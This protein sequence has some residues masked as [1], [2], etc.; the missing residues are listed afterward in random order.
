MNSRLINA[1]KA[2]VREIVAPMQYFQRVR[3]RVVAMQSGR[4]SLQAVK[5]GIWPDMLPISI[6]PGVP[7]VSAN[8]KMGAVVHVE[9]LEGDQSLPRIVGFE[10]AADPN[11][12]P[13]LVSFSGGTKPIA[14]VGDQVAC[15][16]PPVIP[17]SGTVAGSPFVG[18][19]TIPGPSIGIIQAGNPKVTA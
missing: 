13:D 5:K 10:P 12:I 9:F 18:T 3:Y 15:Y 19:M 6:A 1:F 17:V 14:R 7:G 16:F 8:L 11:G 4:V 2:I